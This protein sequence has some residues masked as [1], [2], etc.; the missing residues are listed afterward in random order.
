M[1]S[2]DH[3]EVSRTLARLLPARFSRGVFA[4]PPYIGYLERPQSREL[5]G[6]DG[7]VMVGGWLFGQGGV[8]RGV[9]AR[10]GDGPEVTLSFGLPRPDLAASFAHPLAAQAGFAGAVPVPEGDRSVLLR[11]FAHGAH[12]RRTPCF[13]QEIRRPLLAMTPREVLHTESLRAPFSACLRAATF[14]HPHVRA[15]ERLIFPALCDELRRRGEPLHHLERTLFLPAPPPPSRIAARSATSARR[16][17][18]FVS[19]MFP[20]TDHGGGLRLYDIVSQL[21][22]RHE[23]DLYATYREDLDG[24]SLHKL[25]P[26]LSAARLW[27][28]DELDAADLLSWLARRNLAPDHYD[29]IH[30]EWP[31][32]ARLFGGLA[33]LR[34]RRIFTLMECTTRAQVIGLGRALD[35]HGNLGEV[36]LA[37][38]RAFSHEQ[39]ALR[40]SHVGIAVTDDDAE[41]AA[42]AFGVARPTVIPT[43]LSD[44]LLGRLPPEDDPAAVPP[45]AAFVGYF[46]HYP[47]QDAV[48]WYL[49]N[50][51]DAVR[52]RV[53]GYAL[54]VIGRGDTQAL[55]RL[56]PDDPSLIFEGPVE[57]LLPALARA[58]VGLA[59][60]V[61]G[62]G[63]R[64]KLHQHAVV[65]RPVI[66]TSLGASGLPYADGEELLIADGPQAFADAV[67]RALTDDNLV[68]RLG[69]AA[70]ALVLA[71]FRWAPNIRALE[72]LY[73]A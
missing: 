14:A 8:V 64:G 54:R 49:A 40:G 48:A 10:A 4:E 5:A 68:R 34:S 43:C 23:V 18:L 19:A 32:T 36:A 11:V 13:V 65:G 71:R 42:R 27:P 29:A 58:R 15:A 46:D 67:V 38:C 41:F 7:T 20:S 73:D 47:N 72:A 61:S 33:S 39:A 53:P 55:R 45:H 12:G 16:R 56:R 62:A 44:E 2:V 51:H 31:Q 59:P 3:F 60:I 17:L 9:S 37:L 66:S 35:G 52:A 69:A 24:P 28:S 21:A 22:T 25:A 50:V 57:E 70:R 6:S 26:L 63:I 30:F 1:K